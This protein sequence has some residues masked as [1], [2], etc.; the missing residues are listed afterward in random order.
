MR[1]LAESWMLAEPAIDARR[2][3]QVIESKRKAPTPA[4]ARVRIFR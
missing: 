2:I 1:P 3:A 4:M